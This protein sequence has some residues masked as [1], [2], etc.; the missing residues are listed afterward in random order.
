MLGLQ[1]GDGF[2]CPIKLSPQ[3]FNLL[4]RA[5]IS[6]ARGLFQFKSGASSLCC[7]KY[8][9]HPLKGM[10]VDLHSMHVPCRARL[11]QSVR[12]FARLSREHSRQWTQQLVVAAAAN[13]NCVKVNAEHFR[14]GMGPW[15]S[16]STG[17]RAFSL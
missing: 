15:P 12:E 11:L 5:K 1:L 13:E 7:F 9:A 10:R 4:V 2:Q 17:A 8:S 14:G 6:R 3:S 16:G